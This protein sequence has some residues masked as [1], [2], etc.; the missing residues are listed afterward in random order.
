MAGMT[1]HGLKIGKSMDLRK[2]LIVYFAASWLLCGAVGL[3][4]FDHVESIRL[5]SKIPKLPKSFQRFRRG[6]SISGV[7]AKLFGVS[8]KVSL[9]GNQSSI[10]ERIRWVSDTMYDFQSMLRFYGSVKTWANMQYG[11]PWQD[12]VILKAGSEDVLIYGTS[13]RKKDTTVTLIADSSYQVV[14]FA[15]MFNLSF[16]KVRR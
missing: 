14:K 13:W 7:P 5:D 16:N 15:R 8:G 11:K 9:I 1:P 10:I 2:S 6:N 3:N 12:T 4:Y